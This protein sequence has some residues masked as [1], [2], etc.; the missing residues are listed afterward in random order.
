MLHIYFWS[1]FLSN[2]PL[3]YADRFQASKVFSLKRGEDACDASADASARD[4]SDLDSKEGKPLKP[5]RA[6]VSVKV[7][8]LF[9]CFLLTKLVFMR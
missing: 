6:P 5:P 2:Y 4:E 9:S 1:N 8:G 7:A 3:F